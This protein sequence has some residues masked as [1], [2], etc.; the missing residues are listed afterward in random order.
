MDCS[1]RKLA[2]LLPALA[3]TAAAQSSP[4]LSSRA[5][6]YEDL[7]VKA[8]GP[9]NSR[10]VLDGRTHTGYPIELHMTELG[11][12]QM[13]H[14]AHKHVHEEML[15]LRTGNLDVTIEGKTTRVTAGSTV[16]VNSNEMHGWRNPGPGRA[17]YFVIAF[18]R[19][20]A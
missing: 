11:P 2:L 7:P 4:G 16:Y 8:N 18:G 6:K 12:E 14:A 15:M 1:R 5:L 19:E 20:K 9:N 10:A 3:A 13:P 17:E